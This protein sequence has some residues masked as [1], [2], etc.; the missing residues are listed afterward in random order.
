MREMNNRYEK[1]LKAGKALSGS[2]LFRE[3]AADLIEFVP[4]D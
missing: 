1:G 4:R 3:E 2:T